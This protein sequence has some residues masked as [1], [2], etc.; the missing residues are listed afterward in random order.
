MSTIA[1]GLTIILAVAT[2]SFYV[3]GSLYGYGSPWA[4][5]VCGLSQDLC[6][7]PGWGAIATGVAALV[8]FGLRSF[9]Y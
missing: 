8:Y 4:R 9:R 6:D 5:D 7:N 3:A 1:L 2:V